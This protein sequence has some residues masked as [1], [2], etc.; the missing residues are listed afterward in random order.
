[1]K[2]MLES[3]A[4]RNSD[5]MQLP[6]AIGK[7]ISN[8]PNNPGERVW[9]VEGWGQLLVEARWGLGLRKKGEGQGWGRGCSQRTFQHLDS[10]V[11]LE[12]I[13]LDHGPD[14]LAKVT[15]SNEILKGDVLPLQHWV[16]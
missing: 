8:E 15:L 4:F 5:K 9:A 6:I 13:L 3:P 11:H 2:T 14:D 12:S 1:M 10:G 7:T 16:I